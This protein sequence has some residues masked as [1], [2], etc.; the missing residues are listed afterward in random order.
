MENFVKIYNNI[1][2]LLKD[3]DYIAITN[4]EYRDYDK[5]DEEYKAFKKIKRMTKDSVYSE[6]NMN[7]AI[8]II[9]PKINIS[10]GNKPKNYINWLIC[11]SQDYE[12]YDH[13]VISRCITNEYNR[14]DIAGFETD[15]FSDL[16]NYINNNLIS[17]LNELSNQSEKLKTFIDNVNVTKIKTKYM[18]ENDDED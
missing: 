16:D 8:Y 13:Y 1:T 15:E 11:F 7:Y 10:F 9:N 5:D 6:H 3:T 12:D 18:E 2:K 17:D 4:A 14:L